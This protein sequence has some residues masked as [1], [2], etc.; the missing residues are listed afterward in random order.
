MGYLY[1]VGVAACGGPF[2]DSEASVCGGFVYN[3]GPGNAYLAKFM[4]VEIAHAR[5]WRRI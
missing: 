1:K 3:I 5:G 2:R 4:A